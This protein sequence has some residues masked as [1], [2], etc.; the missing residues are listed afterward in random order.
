MDCDSTPE[1]AGEQYRAEQG[2]A[3]KS[4]QRQAYGEDRSQQAVK[5]WIGGQAQRRRVGD[6]QVR[7]EQLAGRVRSEKGYGQ[8]A[9]PEAEQPSCILRTGHMRLFAYGCG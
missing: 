4:V 8:P 5:A 3:R 7:N 9:Q 6:H 1:I 2:R